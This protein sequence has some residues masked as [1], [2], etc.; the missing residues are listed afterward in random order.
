[1]FLVNVA[2]TLLI[3]EMYSNFAE[4]EVFYGICFITFDIYIYIFYKMA[5]VKCL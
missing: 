5:D 3:N 1:M 4:C 2:D